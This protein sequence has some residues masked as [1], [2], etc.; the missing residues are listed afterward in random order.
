MSAPALTGT[1]RTEA[2]PAVSAH[3]DLWSQH[4][5]QWQWLGS[6]L[7]PA[8]EDI[9]IAER[10]VGQWYDNTRPPVTR[11]LLFGV[12]PEVARMSWPSGTRLAAVDHNRTM[13]RGVWPGAPLGHPALC[14]E[15]HALPF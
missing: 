5:R 8:A 15:W 13:I 6:P 2:G 1:R 9:R 10:C 14:A 4:V 12:T 3:P 11:A 7:R